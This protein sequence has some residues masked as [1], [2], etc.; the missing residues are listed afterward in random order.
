[1]P[2]ADV[3]TVIVAPGINAPV[4]SEMW[5]RSVPVVCGAAGAVLAGAETAGVCGEDAG[6]GG[7]WL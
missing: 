1:M 4:G 3:V 2:P 6:A 5:P 7:A